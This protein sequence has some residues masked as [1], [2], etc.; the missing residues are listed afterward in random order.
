MANVTQMLFGGLGSLGSVGKLDWMS[1][2]VVLGEK[3]SRKTH[4]MVTS[5]KFS[6]V[7]EAAKP[8]QARWCAT[9]HR[10]SVATTEALLL[11]AR[12]GS[13]PSPRQ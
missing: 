13:A 10:H 7:R 2:T 8:S 9:L 1:V 4:S 11:W 5:S 6:A 12:C 3:H